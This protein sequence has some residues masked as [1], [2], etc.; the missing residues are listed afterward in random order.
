[1]QDGTYSLTKNARTI[2]IL[3]EDLGKMNRDY[4]SS[5]KSTWTRIV[6]I[7]KHKST[8]TNRRLE[9]KR[10]KG[11]LV[12]WPLFKWFLNN[13]VIRPEEE[14]IAIAY[15]QQWQAL[16]TPIGYLKGIN[17]HGS[18]GV[19]FQEN[20]TVQSRVIRI[21]MNISTRLPHHLK[22]TSQTKTES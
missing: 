18:P 4:Q 3:T 15:A 13:Q 1:M 19:C 20:A 10:G 2:W 12:I 7:W 22:P 8:L 17:P 14:R 6:Q 21:N 5:R 9:W 11:S 16:P